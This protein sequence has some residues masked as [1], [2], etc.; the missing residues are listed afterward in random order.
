MAP[1]HC[2]GSSPMCACVILKVGPA[3][4]HAPV[5]AAGGACAS[6][7]P[8][9]QTEHVCVFHIPTLLRGESSVCLIRC[10]SSFPQWRQ[11]SSSV[12]L[13]KV[14]L[15]QE[16]DYRG[17]V[18]GSVCVGLMLL[19]LFTLCLWRRRNKHID[20]RRRCACMCV[21]TLRGIPPRE[22]GR[23]SCRERV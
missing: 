9:P 16:Q 6:T 20:G 11:E 2:Q 8:D 5:A 19:L 4:T 23:A 15:A 17:L 22:I 10:F 18:G 12:I 21:W 3:L 7:G 1:T 13:G 14:V